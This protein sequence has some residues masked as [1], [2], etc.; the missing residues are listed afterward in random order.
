MKYLSAMIL[1]LFSVHLGAT[2]HQDF[3][4]SSLSAK[5]DYYEILGVARDSSGVDI[6]KAYRKLAMKFHPDRNPEDQQK[7]V[8]ERF[9]I[10]KEAYETLSDP[11]R[12]KAYDNNS[13]I[14]KSAGFQQAS[15]ADSKLEEMRTRF[16]PEFVNSQLGYLAALQKKSGFAAGYLNFLGTFFPQRNMWHHIN[17]GDFYIWIVESN[18]PQF[19]NENPSLQQYLDLLRIEARIPFYS[20]RRAMIVRSMIE[21]APNLDHAIEFLGSVFIERLNIDSLEQITAM[22][23]KRFG[24]SSVHV[25]SLFMDKIIR[26]AFGY[27]MN[28]SVVNSL[29]PEGIR[30]LS[31]SKE[32]LAPLLQFGQNW[33]LGKDLKYE[34]ENSVYNA[35]KNHPEWLDSNDQLD[36]AKIDLA[37]ETHRRRQAELDKLL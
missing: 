20:E 12:R 13:P 9:K 35:V 4:P 19:Q 28:W 33:D 8:E 10:V 30:F 14:E 34:W 23:S 22:T 6:K 36:S 32:G 7:T 2:T 16:S 3:C 27:Q 26:K 15:P 11:S 1:S 18:F 25:T 24:E 17:N 21:T 5:K 31:N 29:V 37:R